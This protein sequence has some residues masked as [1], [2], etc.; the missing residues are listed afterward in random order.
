MKICC[1]R[2][3]FQ[4]P[5]AFDFV[6]SQPSGFFAKEDC[7][8]QILLKSTK[9]QGDDVYSQVCTTKTC[10]FLDLRQ[11]F[12][13]HRYLHLSQNLWRT[14]LTFTGF[15]SVWHGIR[16]FH[17]SVWHKFSGNLATRRDIT[18]QQNMTA[19]ICDGRTPLG[20]MGVPTCWLDGEPPLPS[21]PVMGVPSDVNRQTDMGESIT[22]PIPLECGR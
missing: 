22:F 19:S 16:V 11:M 4:I 6:V 7:L 17:M 1:K 20:Q 5:I 15:I 21:W 3:I 12:E 9:I 10:Y 8:L 18:C 2:K 14:R 13:P